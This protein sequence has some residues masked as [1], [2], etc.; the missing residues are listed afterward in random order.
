MAEIKIKT[1][2]GNNHVSLTTANA[3]GDA[4]VT[5]PKTSIDFSSAGTLSLD[6]TLVLFF[7]INWLIVGI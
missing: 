5:L 3:S 7:L 2:D 4:T 6:L 1:P